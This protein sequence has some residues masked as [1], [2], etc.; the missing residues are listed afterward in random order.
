MEV[1]SIPETALQLTA[2][3]YPITVSK[4][5]RLID[6]NMGPPTRNKP[7]AEPW[8]LCAVI[9][10]PDALAWAKKTFK[11]GRWPMPV[12]EHIDVFP[13]NDLTD[14]LT[15]YIIQNHPDVWD[16]FRDRYQGPAR[17]PKL[18][19]ITGALVERLISALKR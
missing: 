17:L 6:D 14:I 19:S 5:R 1:Y 3:G 18:K 16:N 9:D 13:N 4:L 10:Y 15:N 7:I 11:S 12:W 2:D 8:R